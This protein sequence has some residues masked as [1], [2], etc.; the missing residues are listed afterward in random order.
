VGAYRCFLGLLVPLITAYLAGRIGVRRGL[1]Q[2]RKQLAFERI[3]D[4]HESTLMAASRFK[5]LGTEFRKEFRNRDTFITSSPRL[6]DL[7]QELEEC[8]SDLRKAVFEALL[9]AE[10]KTVNQLRTVASDIE[11]V[12][13]RARDAAKQPGP[14][15]EFDLIDKVKTLEET[16]NQIHLALVRSIR[17]QLGRDELTGS[18]LGLGPEPARSEKVRGFVLARF[19]FAGKLFPRM[20]P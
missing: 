9:F 20:F 3:I 14:D 16:V 6:T 4:W 15:T 17:K 10:K 12:I 18:D 13:K 11:A 5:H 19:P 7:A 1:E 8:A 2:A